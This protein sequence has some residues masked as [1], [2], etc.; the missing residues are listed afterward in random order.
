MIS[1]PNQV[2]TLGIANSR[3]SDRP[4]G[5]RQRDR[6]HHC[7]VIGQ[8]GTGKSTLLANMAYQ[9]AVAGRGFCLIDPHGDVAELVSK[10]MESKHVYWDLADAESPYGYNPLARVPDF[11]RPLVA[12][13]FVETMKKQWKDSWGP[14]LEHLLR[15][16]VLALLDLPKT[17]LRDVGRMFLQKPFRREVV[18]RIQ[19]DQVRHFWTVEFPAMNYLTTSDGFP[20]IANKLGALL[21]N[22]LVRRAVCEPKEPLRFRRLMDD[23]HPIIVNLAKGRI[24][25]D[26]ANVLG[27]LLLTSIMNAAFS[28][29]DVPEANRR[30]FFLYVDEFHSFTTAVFADMLSEARKYAL[31]LTLSHQHTSQTDRTVF[32]A[33]LGNVGTIMSLRLGAMDA[34]IIARQM[35]DIDAHHFTKLPNYNGYSQ[36]MVDGKKTKLFSFQTRPFLP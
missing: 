3:R 2:T 17:D 16:A 27:G 5:I 10:N 25:T 1:F 32:D 24:G 11:F 31:S 29:H 9:D 7:Y 12:S 15:Y 19:D 30:S 34:P 26:N 36:L 4:F 33:V 21:A 35:G 22:P 20:P 18:A 8:T 23:G 14:R 28:R 13:G 6:L